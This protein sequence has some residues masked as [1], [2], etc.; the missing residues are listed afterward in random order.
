[1]RQQRLRPACAYAQ[2]NQSLCK[3]LEHSMTVKLL[4]EQYL[5]VLSLK[6]GCTCLSESTFVKMPHCWKSH[7]IWLICFL[8]G[9]YI[10]WRCPDFKHDCQRVNTMSKCFCSH[11]L[12]EHDKY[13]GKPL[14]LSTTLGPKLKFYLFPLTRP[15]LKKA[16]L[17]KLYFNFQSRIFF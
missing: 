6:G 16:L 4:T 5:G 8:A 1:M 12:G 17:K 14:E 10:G 3:S 7:V 9:I 11:L 15:T 2:S 13:T